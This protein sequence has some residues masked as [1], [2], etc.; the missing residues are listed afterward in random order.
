MTTDFHALCKELTEALDECQRPYGDQ[1][2]SFLVWKARA[3]L[4]ESVASA[5]RER[6]RISIDEMCEILRSLEIKATEYTDCTILYEV[7]FDQ[8]R[9]ICGTRAALAEQ[10]LPL[11][12]RPDFMVGYHAGFA[13]G[14]FAT[15]DSLTDQPVGATP[16]PV[17]ERWPE[18]YDCDPHERVWVWNPFLDHWKL[19][20]INRSVHTHWLPV[21]AIPVPEAQ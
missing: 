6:S 15:I 9:A 1:P 10:P 4:A 20:R 13:D 17:A 14:K 12:E 18:F 5:E 8:L 3:E 11:K 7:T 19:S 21:N 2:E 16:V